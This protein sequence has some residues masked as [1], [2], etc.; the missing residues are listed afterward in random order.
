MQGSSSLVWVCNPSV[1]PIQMKAIP[2]YFHVVLFIMLSKV[3]LTFK[4]V[5]ESLVCDHSDDNCCALLSCRNVYCIV[6]A[7]FFSFNSVNETPVCVITKM[8]ASLYCAVQ[9][10]SVYYAAQ[11]STH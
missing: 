2:Q 6:K 11:D 3:V 4:F 8:K 5:D 10:H 1:L 9:N 7:V